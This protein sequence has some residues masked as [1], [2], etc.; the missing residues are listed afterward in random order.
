[1]RFLCYQQAVLRPDERNLPDEEETQSWKRTKMRFVDRLR[2][3]KVSCVSSCLCPLVPA[4]FDY[5]KV[6]AKQLCCAE[7]NVD[8]GRSGLVSK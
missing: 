2:E 8:E 5:S 6:S 7:V 1:M 3:R 4:G